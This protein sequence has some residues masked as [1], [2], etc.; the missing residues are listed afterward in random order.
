MKN[1]EEI[2]EFIDKTYFNIKEK[3]IRNK[4]GKQILTEEM[5][6]KMYFQLLDNFAFKFSSLVCSLEYES[7]K[8][9]FEKNETNCTD[10]AEFYGKCLYRRFDKA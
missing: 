1:E 10:D 7:L 3:Y 5:M 8:K 2:Q 6:N 9:C 4:N